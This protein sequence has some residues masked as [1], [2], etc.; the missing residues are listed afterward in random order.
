MPRTTKLIIVE[1]TQQERKWDVVSV[2]HNSMFKPFGCT[3]KPLTVL[4][5]CL[6]HALTSVST[7]RIVLFKHNPRTFPQSLTNTNVRAK[8]HKFMTTATRLH[9]TDETLKL[10][11][12]QHMFFSSPRLPSLMD[13]TM[14][15]NTPTWARHPEW[16]LWDEMQLTYGAIHQWPVSDCTV[17]IEQKQTRQTGVQPIA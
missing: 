3:L 13:R 2:V 10:F 15:P 12:K 4:I 11:S 6:I 1:T 17:K 8:R 5:Q 14:S 7:S 16:F 9:S